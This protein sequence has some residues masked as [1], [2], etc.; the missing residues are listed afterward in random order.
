MPKS[1]SLTVPSFLEQLRHLLDTSEVVRLIQDVT[2]CRLIWDKEAA[3][4]AEPSPGVELFPCFTLY[5]HQELLEIRGAVIPNISNGDTLTHRLR[6]ELGGRRV[7]ML[8]ETTQTTFLL[9]PFH[10]RF[11]SMLFGRIVLHFL[12]LTP[13]GRRGLASFTPYSLEEQ[14]VASYLQSLEGAPCATIKL[15][16]QDNP[17]IGSLLYRQ[18]D[19]KRCEIP[20]SPREEGII[21]A[22]RLFKRLLYF[23]IEGERLFT[24]FVL[25]S[26]LRPLAYYRQHWP[27]LL[28]YQEANHV[29]LDEGLP[30]LKQF[31]LNADGRQT[32][33]ALHG[34]Q[35]VG[36]MRLP[37]NL[38]RHL[39]THQAWRAAL[40]LAT[41]SARGRVSFW[42]PLK[43]RQ[44]ARIPLSVLEYRHGH[45]HIPLFQD[46]F[47]RELE[48]QLRDLCPDCAQ[49]STFQS[50]KKLLNLSRRAGHGGILIIGLTA[51]QLASPDLP[52]ENQVFLATPVPLEEPWLRS[53]L[54]LSKSD[55]ALIVDEHLRA[56]QFR[57]RLKA[58][59]PPLPLDRD[60]LGSGMRHQVTR[61]F[62]A[63]LPNV[64]GLTIS[65]D[66]HISVYRQ[67]KLVSRLF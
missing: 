54:G 47:W 9:S 15:D 18:T 56:V 19:L 14:V 10:L 17:Y 33:L 39:S 28:L 42:L 8:L 7:D 23:P 12:S 46:I 13:E 43:G 40:P 58:A 61:E 49:P 24:G 59:G 35:L 4:A 55:G 38:P 37:E 20:G 57:A 3:A 32:F 22:W 52:I 26:P 60:D 16:S 62:T 45:L 67:G 50:L 66:G 31:L 64:L 48:A 27:H 44:S 51:S 34:A 6:L 29:S 36:L 1:R 63:Y 41:I 53:L 65:Q 21:R 11:L 25:M 5:F 2:A 30:A